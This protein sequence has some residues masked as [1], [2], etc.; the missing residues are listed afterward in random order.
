MTTPI[1]TVLWK[2][3]AWP[4]HETAR[5]QTDGDSW[6][7]DGAATFAHD[8]EPCHLD[9][10][11]RCDAD[12]HTRSA[13]VHGFAGERAVDV[14][15]EVA[16]GVWTMNG[17]PCPQVAACLDVDLNFSPS[18]NLLPI[19]RLNLQIGQSADVR[20]AWLRFPSFELEV[21]E[22]RYTRLAEDRVRY[23]SFTTDFRAELLVRPSGLVVDYQNIWLAEAFG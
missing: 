10:T 2:C 14:T 4:G 3:L 23:E 13:R 9:Y 11:I 20:A 16:D 15:I 21:L 1:E 7:L 6:L 12:W 22:Q 19:R 18:T 8:G 17:K 5:L